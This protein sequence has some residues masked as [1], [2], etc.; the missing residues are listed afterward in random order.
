LHAPLDKIGCSGDPC[1][2]QIVDDR[3][4]LSVGR[5]TAFLSMNGFEH[6]AHL[7]TLMNMKDFLSPADVS[8]D[9]AALGKTILLQWL[10]RSASI[11]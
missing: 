9:F 2:A 6:V 4:R 3:T 1:G 7:A 8:A 10:A 11:S 5:V